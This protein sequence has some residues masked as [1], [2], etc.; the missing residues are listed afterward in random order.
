MCNC[1]C[2]CKKSVLKLCVKVFTAIHQPV[3]FHPCIGTSSAQG[4]ICKLTG[5][6]V[7]TPVDV[8]ASS[9]RLTHT[10]THTHTHTQ[11]HTH[12]H[13]DTQTHRHTDTHTHTH[14]HTH[15]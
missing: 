11:T 15:T 3:I 13:T 6:P 9:S 1:Q 4:A 8:C 5:I 14:T 12:R 10:H 7:R 2:Q